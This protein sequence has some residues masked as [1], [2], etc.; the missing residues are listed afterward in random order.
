VELSTL[1][2]FT[3]A[4]GLIPKI[5]KL[6]AAAADQVKQTYDTLAIK[7]ETGETTEELAKRQMGRVVHSA[8]EMTKALEARMK[9]VYTFQVLGIAFQAY[10][11]TVLIEKVNHAYQIHGDWN[12]SGKI[13]VETA[14]TDAQTAVAHAQGSNNLVH[15]WSI[16]IVRTLTFTAPQLQ[17]QN[18]RCCSMVRSLLSR[19]ESRRPMLMHFQQDLEG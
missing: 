12:V 19:N 14:V 5:A 16:L 1:P 15:P 6:S 13:R 17:S 18:K 3:A 2:T 4:E 8:P 10:Q 7:L 11:L 9:V